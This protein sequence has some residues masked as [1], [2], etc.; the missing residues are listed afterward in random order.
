MIVV[1]VFMV[2]MLTCRSSWISLESLALV[3]Q[4]LRRRT[5][6]PTYL[7]PLLCIETCD[8]EVTVLDD[9]APVVLE[10]SLHVACSDCD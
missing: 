5:Y 1:D 7:P 3:R 9:R 8:G 2:G 10:R 4:D 6:G